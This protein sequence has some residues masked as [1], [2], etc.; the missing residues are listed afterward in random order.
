MNNATTIMQSY[1]NWG[2]WPFRLP[3]CTNACQNL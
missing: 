1:M 2:W 3:N